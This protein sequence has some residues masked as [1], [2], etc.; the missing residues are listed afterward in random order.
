MFYPFG[1]WWRGRLPHGGRSERLGWTTPKVNAGLRSSVTGADFRRRKV[2]RAK[3]GAGKKNRLEG[4][5]RSNI[6]C[7]N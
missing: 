6:S 1:V 3:R 2:R 4:E 7:R 5:K